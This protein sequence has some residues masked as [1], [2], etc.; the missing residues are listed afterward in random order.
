MFL[1]R[2]ASSAYFSGILYFSKFLSFSKFLGSTCLMLAPA[3]IILPSALI[4]SE[5]GWM[6][7]IVNSLIRGSIF[8]FGSALLAFATPLA[9]F[10]C[11]RFK[12]ARVLIPVI[13][14]ILFVVHPLG[15]NAWQ[16]ALLW[17]VPFLLA[18]KKPKTIYLAISSSF[19]AHAVGSVVW[20]YLFPTL[21]SYLW[22]ALIPKVIIERT[23]VAGGIYCIAYWI[24]NNLTQKLFKNWLTFLPTGLLNN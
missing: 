6:A 8:G 12:L 7:L 14:F 10:L 20:L 22:L 24:D 2:L 18:F 11:W 1:K 4:F 15:S 21:S 23:V 13:S 16:Y 9:A 5:A 17:V 19:A 3:S